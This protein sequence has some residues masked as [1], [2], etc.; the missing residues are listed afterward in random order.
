MYVY[1]Y[2]Y[3]TKGACCFTDAGIDVDVGVRFG[4]IFANSLASCSRGN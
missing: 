3:I 4:N 1:I 2:I